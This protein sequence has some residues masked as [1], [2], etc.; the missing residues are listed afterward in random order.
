MKNIVTILL[1]CLIFFGC[2]K[3]QE[4]DYY[5]LN[6]VLLDYDSS[7]P[8]SGVKVKAIH[9]CILPC[10]TVDS[11]DSDAS[12]RVSFRIKKSISEVTL[13]AE[14]AGYLRPHGI[15]GHYPE[16]IDRTDT[17]YFTRPSFLN[18]TIHKNGIYLPQDSVRI[19]VE[20]DYLSPTYFSSASRTLYNDNTNLPDRIFN[21]YTWYNAPNHT[22]LHFYWEV[23][24]N[25]NIISLK[26]DSANLVQFGTQNFT[27]N[28]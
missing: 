16:K 22:K 6:G 23:I 20:G 12:G 19:H 25:G 10:T 1:F 5:I 27:I 17:L 2:K 24:R 4:E 15:Q 26:A 8:I 7:A 13:F 28:Y 18:V 11:A 21:L 14:K 3:E 9:N